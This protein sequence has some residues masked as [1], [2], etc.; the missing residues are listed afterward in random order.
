MGLVPVHQWAVSFCEK[1]IR[2]PDEQLHKQPVDLTQLYLRL[3]RNKADRNCRGYYF[4]L[5]GGQLSPPLPDSR[6]KCSFSR[7]QW[8]KILLT[9][10]IVVNFAFV[11]DGCRLG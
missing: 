10:W 11:A 8:F 1:L 9:L 2:F 5:F 7:I 3:K 6:V 4:E